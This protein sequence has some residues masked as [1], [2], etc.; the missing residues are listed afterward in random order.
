MLI[1]WLN[2][3]RFDRGLGDS[4]WLESPRSEQRFPSRPYHP[5]DD[6]EQERLIL[7]APVDFAPV[8]NSRHQNK[9]VRIIDRIDNATVADSNSKVIVPGE[10]RDS[11]RPWLFAQA[12]YSCRDPLAS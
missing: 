5:V 6:A 8:R 11:M 10:L 2:D 9:S 7:S 12:I 1:G 4:D 3:L